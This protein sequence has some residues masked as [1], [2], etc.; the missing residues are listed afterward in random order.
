MVTPRDPV[1]VI[2]MHRSGTSMLTR[3]LQGFGLYMGRGATRN[4]ECRWTNLLNEWI[5]RQASATWER[6]EGVDSLLADPDARPLVAD[7]LAGVTDGPAAIR[8]LGL[9]RWLR[10]RSLCAISEPWGWKEPRNTFTLPFW[11][12]VFPK[13]RVL[14]I[15][16]HGVDV[17]ASLR[18]RRARAM[19]AAAA[20]YRR[21]RAGYVNNPFAPKRSGFAHSPRIGDP[22]GGLD[23]WRAYTDRAR[24]HV[25]NLGARA[26]EMRYEDLLFEPESHLRAVVEFCGLDVSDHGLASAAAG[27]RPDRAFAY[28][29]DPALR[30]FGEENEKALRRCGYEP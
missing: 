18:S 7:Y 11:L 3:S 21:G 9:R 27:F 30:A 12:E 23:L 14:H 13:A 24:G 2:G 28:R 5:F 26:L 17:M 8:Y 6:P 25:R 10:Y 4:E 15:M 1:I 22:A 16:R 29:N 19:S 20:R